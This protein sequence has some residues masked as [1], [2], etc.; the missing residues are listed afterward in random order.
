MILGAVQGVTE[1]LPISSSGHLL[2]VPWAGGWDAPL[3][4][5]LTF[6]V[7]VLTTPPFTF[8]AWG[9]TDSV[10]VSQ[11]LIAISDEGGSFDTF[12]LLAEGIQSGDPIAF[13][14]QDTSNAAVARTSSGFIANTW[15]H[16]CAVARSTTDRSVFLNGG[17]E[18]TH[19]QS[20][21]PAG[22][23]NTAVGVWNRASTNHKF[24]GRI[25]EVGIWNIA[26]LLA[27]IEALA[28]GFSP[29][30]IRPQSLVLY[31]P[32]VRDDDEDLIGGRSFT[33]VNTPSIAAHTRVYRPAATQMV[34]VPAAAAASTGVDHAVTV[35]S[36]IQIEHGVVVEHIRQ[37]NHEIVVSSVR[38][39]DHD[40]VVG[41][42]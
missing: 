14:V 42:S 33:A 40:V 13:R 17:S 23:D 9:Y 34:I 8:S 10:T 7:A 12:Q 15:F 26:L 27:E 11:T 20:V 21:A 28:A 30:L 29:L 25:A 16:A 6:A 41:V 39:A 36:L 3:L 2:L 35:S 38:Q 5:S 19:S 4:N 1:F 22:L 18:G 37:T 31:L 24:S 32:L